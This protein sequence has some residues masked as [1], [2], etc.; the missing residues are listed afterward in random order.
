MTLVLA[1]SGKKQS[2]KTTSGHFVMSLCMSKL[3]ISKD[4]QINENGEIV[5]SDLLGNKNYKG[6]FSP[7]KLYIG[8]NDYILGQV[9]SKLDP[10]IKLYSFADPLKQSICIDILGLSWEQCYG[11][12]EQKNSLTSLRWKDMPEYNILWTRQKGYD[13]SG[14]MTARQVME[15]VG[16]DIFRQMY[17]NV[18]AD[19]TIRKIQKDKPKIAV[20]TD[21][22]FPNE[23]ESI[24]GIGGYVI[25][26]TKSPFKSDHISETI[27]D[28]DKYDW[29]NFD[30]VID[31]ENMSIYEQCMAI[32]NALK[33]VLSL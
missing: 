16:T 12:D 6:I 30:F 1:F 28:K 3:G 9:K 32:Q 24:S 22:R 13:E 21:C 20:I 27:L 29:D 5:V 18:W 2:G 4:L 23:V 10:A 31:N 8:D 25:R 11:S 7:E 19:A 33:E 14:Y 15:H 17:A 26:L